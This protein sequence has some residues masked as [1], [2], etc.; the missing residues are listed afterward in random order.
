MYCHTTNR[1]YTGEYQLG[2]SQLKLSESHADISVT[3]PIVLG[4][5][6]GLWEAEA[7]CTRTHYYNRQEHTP[8]VVSYVITN[9]VIH[10][11]P[12]LPLSLIV[13]GLVTIRHGSA[14]EKYAIDGQEWFKNTLMSITSNSGIPTSERDAGR[15]DG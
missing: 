13:W 11:I 4:A 1:L 3:Q 2:N 9:R 7:F 10:M 8:V 12:N 14:L 5:Y 6:Q 15:E